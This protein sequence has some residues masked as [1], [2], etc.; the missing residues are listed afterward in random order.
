MYFTWFRIPFTQIDTPYI[1]AYIDKEKNINKAIQ[2]GI[3]RH[4]RRWNTVLQR[5][6]KIMILIVPGRPVT[7]RP[8]TLTGLGVYQKYCIAF[9]RTDRGTRNAH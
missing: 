2:I 7:S 6:I 5:Q 8:D 3:Y 9:L 4:R 1:T